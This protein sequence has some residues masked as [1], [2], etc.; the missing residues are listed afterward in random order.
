MN[1]TWTIKEFSSLTTKELYDILA[2]RGE[3]FTVEQ[4]CFCNDCDYKDIPSYHLL[5]EINGELV[6]YLRILPKNISYEE[7]SIGR[8]LVKANFRKYGL[9]R[10]MMIEALNF[11]KLDL[12]ESSI[13]I[14]AQSYISKFYESLGFK[15]SS[16]EYLECGIPHVKMLYNF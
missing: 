5:G 14:S 2:L 9:A 3:V 8:V 1:V 6:A 7:V 13:K 11:I 16:E 10:K 4:E 15:I 12:K